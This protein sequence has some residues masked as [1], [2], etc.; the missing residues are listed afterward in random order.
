M[1]TS[2][3]FFLGALVMALLVMITGVIAAVTV[4]EAVRPQDQGSSG[5]QTAGI[6]AGS[7]TADLDLR[8]FTGIETRGSWEIELVRSDE[9]AVLVTYP[10]ARARS[11]DV[12]MSDGRLVLSY[13]PEFRLFGGSGRYTARIAMPALDSVDIAGAVK[14]RLSGFTGDTLRL[15]ASGAA[16]IEAHDSRYG[17]LTLIVSGAGNADLSDMPV[18]D[19]EVVLSGA[20]Q[21]ALD[22]NGGDLSGTISGAGRVRYRGTVQRQNIVTSGFSSVEPIN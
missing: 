21:I 13:R 9:W 1:R 18:V 22:M 17:A 5:T 8:D 10:P 2:Q 12:H 3:K 11:V 14:L 15:V 19:A 4:I 7:T 20:G 6:D 16:N